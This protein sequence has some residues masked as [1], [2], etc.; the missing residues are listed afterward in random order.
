MHIINGTI[1]KDKD[2]TTYKINVLIN[3]TQNIYLY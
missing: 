2:V 3:I 1:H